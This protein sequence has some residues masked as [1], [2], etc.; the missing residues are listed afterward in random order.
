MQADPLNVP[1]CTIPK[2]SREEVRVQLTE[3]KGTQ[4]ADFRIWA[5][6]TGGEDNR[7]PTKQGLAISFARLPEFARAAAEAERQARE[8]GLIGGGA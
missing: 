7:G 6:G 4:F 8:L 1:I 3:F 2:N 5:S